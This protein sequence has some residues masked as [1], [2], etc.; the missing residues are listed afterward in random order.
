M[1]SYTDAQWAKIQNAHKLSNQTISNYVKREADRLGRITDVVVSDKNDDYTI[2][3]INGRHNHAVGC[4]KAGDSAR[5]VCGGPLVPGPWAYT[6]GL[7]ACLTADYEGKAEELAREAQR[8][9]DIESGDLIRVDG[10]VYR[11]EIFRR[12]YI[13]LHPVQD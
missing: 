2:L 8:T 13:K 4:I 7:G 10:N 9:I 1:S 12:E 11:V 6:F 5:K 3:V